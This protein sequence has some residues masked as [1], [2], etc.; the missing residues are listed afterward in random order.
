MSCPV[1][2]LPCNCLS[3]EAVPFLVWDWRLRTSIWNEEEPAD[4]VGGHLPPK[5]TPQGQQ[6]V[7]VFPEGAAVGFPATA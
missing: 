6:H 4:L 2:V 5:P 7:P 3:D 1:I